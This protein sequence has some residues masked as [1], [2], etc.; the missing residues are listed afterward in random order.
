MHLSKL[1]ETV[2]DRE[3]WGSIVRAVSNV[4]HILATEQHQRRRGDAQLYFFILPAYWACP[5]ATLASSLRVPNT[6]RS[7]LPCHTFAPCIGTIFL[8]FLWTCQILSIL[9]GSAHIPSIPW[10]TE[11][12]MISFLKE[13]FYSFIHSF[14]HPY[15]LW[16]YMWVLHSWTF[17]SCSLERFFW[18]GLI[19]LQYYIQHKNM[20]CASDFFYVP[21]LY[22]ALKIWYMLSKLLT[23]KFYNYLE[24][25]IHEFLNVKKK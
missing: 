3:A 13:H 17:N 16:T 20:N 15:S 22:T 23:K 25:I 8:P 7:P 5:P 24:R 10:H 19:S 21:N 9:H 11:S 2:K 1:Q 14:I 12:T 4:G 6:A 18:L